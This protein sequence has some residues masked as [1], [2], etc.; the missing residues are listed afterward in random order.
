MARAERLK[1]DVARLEQ[2]VISP[3]FPSQ[4]RLPSIRRVVA[5]GWTL[6]DEANGLGLMCCGAWPQKGFRR[7]VSTQHHRPKTYISRQA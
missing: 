4:L 5:R 6:G 7:R 1:E 3:N 2:E